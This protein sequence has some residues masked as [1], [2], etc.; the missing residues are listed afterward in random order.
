MYKKVYQLSLKDCGVASLL[1]IIRHYKGDNTFENIRKLTKCSNNGITALNLVEASNK[2][3]FKARG[4]KCEYE[5]LSN[6]TIPSICHIVFNNGY[7]HYIVLYKY[8]NEYVVVFDPYY[9]MKR[10]SKEEFLKIWDKIVIELKPIRKLDIIKE[11]NYKK[12]LSIV[13]KNK[14]G[15]IAIIVLSLFSIIFALISNY[16]FKNLIDGFN[17]FA[18][19]I[20]FCI[21]IMS[22]EIIEFI[23]NKMLIKLENKIDKEITITMHNNMLSLSNYYFNSR[24]SGDIVT[25]F[26]DIEHIKN[27]LIKLPIFSFIDIIL[28]IITSILLLS[29]NIKLTIIFYIICLL[30]FLILILF[31]KKIRKL[32]QKNQE[33]NSLKNSILIENINLINTIKNL[34]IKNYRQEIFNNSYNLYININEKC[35]KLY[36][37]LNF[38]KNIMLYIGINIILFM[39][40]KLVNNDVLSLSNLILFDSLIIYFVEPLKD[41]CDLS[42][43]IKNGINSIKRVDE[44]FCYENIQIENKNIDNYDI[45][46][47]NLTFSYDNYKNIINN[48]NYKI[49]YKDKIFV[50][51]VSGSGKSTI[52]KLL[53]KDYETSNMIYIN[54]IEINDIEISRYVTYVSQEEKLFNDTLYSNIVLDNNADNIN[55]VLEITGLNT[56]LKNR[57]MSLSSIV[58]ENGSN[59]SVG[60]RQR[61]ILSRTLLKNNKILILDESLSGLDSNDE[62]NVMKKILDKYVDRTIIYISHS[63]ICDNLFNKRLNI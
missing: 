19:L 25:K 56:V 45:T 28:I 17:T 9:G 32:I 4:I 59:L 42:P 23:R 30:Y 47:K 26:N 39:G 34:N 37:V 20:L 54:D 53:N 18:I 29:I 24:L 2:L 12:F 33:S 63:N 50:T 10:H 38:F 48:F 5:D 15:Y 13:S 62:Y 57:N 22:K 46:F 55:E 60:E 36:N 27:L 41:M 7:N 21:I 3:G 51:G 8:T 58:E 16:Y 11:N 49:Y 1:S 52:F 35:N 61:V 44:I 40:I 6:I 31:N 14:Y 43:I